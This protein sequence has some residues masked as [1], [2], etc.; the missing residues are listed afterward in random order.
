MAYSHCGV[1]TSTCTC[2]SGR[3]TAND[4][5][6]TCVLRKIHDKCNADSDCINAVAD[7]YC[8]VISCQCNSG[9]YVTGNGTRCT[10]RRISDECYLETDCADAVTN[11]YCHKEPQ[12]TLTRITKVSNEDIVSNVSD[13]NFTH[14][15]KTNPYIFSQSNFS[16]NEMSLNDT[17]RLHSSSLDYS[18]SEWKVLSH[19][20]TDD[21]QNSAEN[22]TFGVKAEYANNV[23][24]SLHVTD[25][26]G[27]V[28]H[29]KRS[30]LDG[31]INHSEKRN[32]TNTSLVA[33]TTIETLDLESSS[34][35]AKTTQPTGYGMSDAN[36]TLTIN[37]TT[38]Q[39]NMA[40]TNPTD[41]Y[42]TT[43]S[44]TNDSLTINTTD[45]ATTN[46]F[47]ANHSE[48]SS[49]EFQK[50]TTATDSL[51]T[52]ATMILESPGHCTCKSGY[53]AGYN[54]TTCIKRVIG[55]T[56]S[57]LS[58]CLDVINN[59]TC[60]NITFW[61]NNL[62]ICAC[63]IGLKKAVN[64]STCV[65]RLIGEPCLNSL[66]CTSVGNSTCGSNSSSC[67]CDDAF[68]P[69]EDNTTCILRKVGDSCESDTECSTAVNNSLCSSY[70][71]CYSDTTCSVSKDCDQEARGRVDS[72][73]NSKVCTCTLGYLPKQNGSTCIKR[74]SRCPQSRV[75][76][77]V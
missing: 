45:M 9:Y 47:T 4:D 35:E 69:S 77:K 32:S 27:N 44:G 39:G 25:V 24:I 17:R 6:T 23:N 41:V 37:N 18:Q 22:V 43:Q 60:L 48:L 76:F 3:H 55:D 20:L 8:D 65:P 59:S 30:M 5:D 7:S 54:K 63:D 51:V 21:V 40:T 66:D 58:D 62:Q 31:A 19:F 29:H 11:S 64:G 53:K 33:E 13:I 50:E 74:E 46:E 12:E 57:V 56:C 67:E 10:R 73:P 68:Y 70:R 52:M 16:H 34:P 75:L 49:E 38:V 61:G 28:T 72:C 71:G 36:D 1:I 14:N 26:S 2:N 15:N 42:E